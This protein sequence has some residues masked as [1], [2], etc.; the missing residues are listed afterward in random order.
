[1]LTPALD[2]PVQSNP[3]VFIF[4]KILRGALSSTNHIVV[5]NEKCLNAQYGE[6][7]KQSPLQ[8]LVKSVSKASTLSSK[9]EVYSS[10]YVVQKTFSGK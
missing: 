7:S 4:L 9:D 6:Q 1:M 10:I 8:V 2:S 5:I 3:K